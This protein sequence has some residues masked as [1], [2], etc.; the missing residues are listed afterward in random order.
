MTGW[1]AADRAHILCRIVNTSQPRSANPGQMFAVAALGRRLR[2]HL[3]FNLFLLKLPSAARVFVSKS[4]EDMALELLPSRQQD[5]L[6]NYFPLA[7]TEFPPHTN[8]NHK[9]RVGN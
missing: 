5:K 8:H 2:L 3:H 7:V 6:N 4:E 9:F 1:Q